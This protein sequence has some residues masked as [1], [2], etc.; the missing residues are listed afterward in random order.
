MRQKDH[1]EGMGQDNTGVTVLKQEF[2][3]ALNMKEEDADV[4][5][6]DKIQKS[7]WKV[8][9]KVKGKVQKKERDWEIGRAHV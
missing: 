3:R 9:D 2:F 4:E 6:T 1:Q 5:L 7:K 8:E